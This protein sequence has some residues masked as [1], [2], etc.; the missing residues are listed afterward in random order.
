MENLFARTLKIHVTY[1]FRSLRQTW[2]LINNSFVQFF[3][4]YIPFASKLVTSM[5][6]LK[7]LLGFLV[8]RDNN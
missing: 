5:G 8:F 2:R 7:H 4:A 1:I 3:Q 6:I